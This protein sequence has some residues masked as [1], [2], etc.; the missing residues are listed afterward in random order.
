MPFAATLRQKA[1]RRLISPLLVPLFA[2]AAALLHTGCSSIVNSSTQKT[3]FVASYT[4]GN[5]AGAAL[6]SSQKA[7]DRAWTGDG[8]MWMLEAGKCEFSAGRYTRSLDEFEAAEERMEDYDSRA[9]VNLRAMTYEGASAATNQNALPYEGNYVDRTMLNAYKALA[10]FAMERPEDALV[11]IRRM[12]FRQKKTVE[13]RSQEI[14]EAEEDARKNRINIKGMI[15]DSPDMKRLTEELNAHSNKTYSNYMIPFCSYLSAVCYLW[16]GERSEALLDLRNLH[17]MDGAN[18]LIRQDY[19]TLGRQ[20][21]EKLPD[22]MKDVPSW[23]HPMGD[24][25]VFILAESGVCAW[26][27]AVTIHLPLPPPVGYTGFAFPVLEYSPGVGG[28]VAWRD[29]FGNSGKTVTICD[30]DAVMGQEYRSSLVPMIV[31]T[32]VSTLV[33]EGTSVVAVESARR[34]GNDAAWILALVGT[35]IYKFLFNTADTR[36]WQ[37]LPKEF[38]ATHLP[39]P[40]DGIVRIGREGSP[41]AVIQDVSVDT[42]KKMAVIYVQSPSQGVF[43]VRIFQFD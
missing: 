40:K 31:R 13:R 8:L 5:F 37:T 7:K 22:D 39:M 24:K 3:D 36:S 20:M 29:N 34:S 32:V 15:D 23:Q 9:S 28:A 4:G 42:S 11:E 18:Q 17:E 30:M 26:R 6:Y 25:V 2:G 21:G 12:N 27:R 1:R 14:R 33:K 16:R 10:Y 43:S 19:A 41:G 38:Q 35:G